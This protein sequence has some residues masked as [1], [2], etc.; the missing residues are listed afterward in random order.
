ML[1]LE[2]FMWSRWLKPANQNPWRSSS[3]IVGLIIVW[4]RHGSTQ[5]QCDGTSH[6]IQGVGDVPAR[7]WSH[8]DNQHL[9][10]NCRKLRYFK[11]VVILFL[12][13]TCVS[14]SMSHIALICS[15]QLHVHM[16]CHPLVGRVP[17]V[18][19]SPA[20]EDCAF[21]VASLPTAIRQPK[22]TKYYA[23]Y[24]SFCVMIGWLFVQN[25]ENKT[26]KYRTWRVPIL[27]KLLR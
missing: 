27:T 14:F 21:I 26:C 9:S 4:A 15:Y 6:R 25:S 17:L 18:V 1:R 13:F 10:F 24:D 5:P 23:Q 20:L 2:W 8:L 22:F 11:V 7:V 19:P 12:F 3:H 16:F